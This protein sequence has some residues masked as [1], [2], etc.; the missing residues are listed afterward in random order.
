MCYVWVGSDK[1]EA[2]EDMLSGD[3]YDF[4]RSPSGDFFSYSGIYTRMKLRGL[5]STPL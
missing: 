4:N 1:P 2:P 5:T 3:I